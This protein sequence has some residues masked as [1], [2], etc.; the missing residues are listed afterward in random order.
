MFIP[1]SRAFLLLCICMEEVEEWRRLGTA[2]D[3]A[4][5]SASD[6]VPDPEAD[7]VFESALSDLES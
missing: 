1:E 4:S 3:C 5:E 7:P 2:C 6:F